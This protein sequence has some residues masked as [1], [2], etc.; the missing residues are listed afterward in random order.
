L[1]DKAQKMNFLKLTYITMER[2][3]ILEQHLIEAWGVWYLEWQKQMKEH[4]R[5]HAMSAQAFVKGHLIAAEADN[6]P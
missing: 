3:L 2:E 6:S 5:R 1:P 4:L